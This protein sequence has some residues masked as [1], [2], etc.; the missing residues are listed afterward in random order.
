MPRYNLEG[1]KTMKHYISITIGRN[2]GTT[3]MGAT[4]WAQFGADITQAISNHATIDGQ[5]FAGSGAGVWAG[6]SE[7]AQAIIVL[8]DEVN[9]PALRQDLASLAK[10]YQQDAIGCAILELPN[11]DES[12]VYADK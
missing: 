8:A 6:E 9:Q 3:P 4:K 5:I 7:Q 12:L 10:K 2:I 1:Y 11:G